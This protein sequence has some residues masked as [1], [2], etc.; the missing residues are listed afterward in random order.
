MFAYL[1]QDAIAYNQRDRRKEI[2]LAPNHKGS[3]CEVLSCRGRLAHLIVPHP[4]CTAHN[5]GIPCRR[6]GRCHPPCLRQRLWGHV[7]PRG[8]LDDAAG[9]AVKV[10]MYVDVSLCQVATHNLLVLLSVPANNHH[11]GLRESQRESQRTPVELAHL[12]LGGPT[13]SA[14][15]YAMVP[16]R[17][18]CTCTKGVRPRRERFQTTHRPPTTRKFSDEMNQRNFSNQ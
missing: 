5:L 7:A 8:V 17:F 3:R 2:L 10:G 13:C 16:R 15:K 14:R 1:E 6:E 9:R 18:T 11:T 12:A 4:V